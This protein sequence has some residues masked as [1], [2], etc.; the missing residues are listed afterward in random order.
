MLMKIIANFVTNNGIINDKD[1]E[2]YDSW[3]NKE[4]WMSIREKI[5]NEF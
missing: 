2:D 5:E 1:T 4:L 3:E